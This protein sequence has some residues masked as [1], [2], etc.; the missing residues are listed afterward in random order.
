MSTM[1]TYTNDSPIHDSGKLLKQIHNKNIDHYYTAKSGS[2]S[3]SSPT[4]NQHQNIN[5]N[6]ILFES[7]VNSHNY[8]K[9]N[10]MPFPMPPFTNLTLNN[11]NKNASYSTNNKLDYPFPP[12]LT[13][14]LNLG[15]SLIPPIR[16][17]ASI[18]K[19]P[20]T[21]ITN[22]ANTENLSDYKI[23]TKSIKDKPKQ[24]LWIKRTQGT[25]NSIIHKNG[26]PYK[27]PPSS[28]HI[29][30]KIKAILPSIQTSFKDEIGSQDSSLFRDISSHL[31]MN[32][33]KFLP[34]VGQRKIYQHVMTKKKHE[35][36]I[37]GNMNGY[38]TIK[39][40]TTLACLSFVDSNQPLIEPYEA[41]DED[42][43]KQECKVLYLRK[44][45][46][47]LIQKL[48]VLSH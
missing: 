9:A 38:E 11:I 43:K 39:A 44:R 6:K 37:D 45:L 34:V 25:F 10:S 36:N 23:N 22:H 20:V 13:D 12:F 30:N 5:K 41:L 31:H 46:T 1:N 40:D 48:E 24:L 21:K 19:Q 15:L 26:E 33:W 32:T 3:I 7:S 16:R 42:I 27:I 28:Y 35:L 4:F 47:K 14:T 17:T 18:F 29:S 8:F 2:M